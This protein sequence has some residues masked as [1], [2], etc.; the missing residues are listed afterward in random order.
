MSSLYYVT[1][2]LKHKK[3]LD[4]TITL[5]FI[6]EGIL[7]LETTKLRNT[8]RILVME[9]T[10]SVEQE[11]IFALC[12]NKTFEPYLKHFFPRGENGQPKMLHPDTVRSQG[13]Y[14]N[15]MD[16]NKSFG[17]SILKHMRWEIIADGGEGS[18]A[19]E[20]I[21]KRV[22]EFHRKQPMS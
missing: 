1:S 3:M 6:D 9:Q 5:P 10:H 19:E 2:P 22:L 4:Q 13:I 7:G 17:E 15:L 16:E 11:K 20:L 14:E 8:F 12:G 18:H 21:L